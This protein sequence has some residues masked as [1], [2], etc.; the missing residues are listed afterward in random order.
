MGFSEELKKTSKRTQSRE[1]G[2]WQTYKKVCNENSSWPESHFKILQLI[3][4]GHA[5]WCCEVLRKISGC[6]AWSQLFSL[7]N[8]REQNVEE[9]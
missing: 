6:G 1:E 9:K 5:A 8:F 2:L 4:I 7:F 3:T